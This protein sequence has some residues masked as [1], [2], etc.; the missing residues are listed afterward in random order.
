MQQK[1]IGLYVQESTLNTCKG[2]FAKII[3]ELDKVVKA[4]K[5]VVQG[6]KELAVKSARLDIVIPKELDISD[7]KNHLMKHLM[8]KNSNVKLNIIIK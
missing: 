5:Y 3:D 2:S 7:L 8:E 6:G 4:K 1:S